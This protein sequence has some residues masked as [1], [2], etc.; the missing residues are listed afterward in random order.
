MT[1]AAAAGSS[2]SGDGAARG[3]SA[4]APTEGV[5]GELV[6][7]AASR[8][9]SA[10][11]FY[12]ADASTPALG[13]ASAG[14]I[15]GVAGASTPALVAS[16]VAALHA[17]PP[18]P[19]PHGLPRA[20]SSSG[21]G[22]RSLGVIVAPKG[23]HGSSAGSLLSTLG[24]AGPVR[25][26]A[27]LAAGGV[28]VGSG[29]PMPPAALAPSAAATSSSSAASMLG[30][31]PAPDRTQLFE[32]IAELKT[33]F[34]HAVA[35]CR[36]LLSSDVAAGGT[37]LGPAGSRQEGS[38]ASPS[39]TLTLHDGDKL[40]FYSYFKQ[41]TQGDCPDPAHEDDV[42]MMLLAAPPA[43][44]GAASSRESTSGGTASARSRSPSPVRGGGAGH[45][46][47]TLALAKAKRDAWR[48]CSGMRRREAMRAFVLLLDRCVPGWDA[49]SVMP[50]S[51]P[52]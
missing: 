31:G 50:G 17:A 2:A 33:A 29:S 37:V 21:S 22:R 11:S 36:P 44:S 51:G 5:G 46:P 15:I 16:A 45:T 26:P 9:G 10:E 3:G 35:F 8:S 24:D 48:R 7:I 41:A 40:S 27:P 42:S 32:S 25:D 6:L 1:P 52:A 49:V 38:F 4:G 43:P 14:S 19:P 20:G 39:A 28:G 18:M 34:L 23:D 12:S 47:A 13:L 30:A